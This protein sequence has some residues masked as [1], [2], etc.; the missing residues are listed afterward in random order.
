LESPHIVVGSI[1]EIVADLEQRR[2][3]YGISHIVIS[4]DKIDEFAPIVAQ[5]AGR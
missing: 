4:D 2:E 1:E 3:R 5:L